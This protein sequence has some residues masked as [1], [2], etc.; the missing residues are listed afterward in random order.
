MKLYPIGTDLIF[1]LNE[2]SLKEK[3]SEISKE[4]KVKAPVQVEEI[5]SFTEFFIDQSTDFETWWNWFQRKR[6]YTCH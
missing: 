6:G 1:D 2:L 3:P 5:A 4:L